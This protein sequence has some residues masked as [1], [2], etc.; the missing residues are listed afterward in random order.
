MPIDEAV[1]INST[2]I[3]DFPSIKKDLVPHFSANSFNLFELELVFDP[4]TRQSHTQVIIA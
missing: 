3:S 1:F 4:M 2:S